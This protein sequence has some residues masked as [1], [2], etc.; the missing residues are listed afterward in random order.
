MTKQ[1]LINTYDSMSMPEEHVEAIEARLK[2][3]YDNPSPSS[4]P[5]VPEE[6]TREYKFDRKKPSAV[7]A[8]VIS[9]SAAAAA[10]LLVFGGRYLINGLPISSDPPLDAETEETSEPPYDTEEIR[11]ESADDI[12]GYERAGCYDEYEHSLIPGADSGKAGPLFTQRLR[13]GKPVSVVRIKITSANSWDEMNYTEYH[14][15]ITE[16]LS[17]KQL[18]LNISNEVTFR[19]GSTHSEQIIGEPSLAAGDELIA[20]AAEDGGEK[21]L[22]DPEELLFECFTVKGRNFA[23]QRHWY[24]LD[25]ADNAF[26]HQHGDIRRIT[27]VTDDPVSYYGIYEQGELAAALEKLVLVSDEALSLGTEP[28]PNLYSDFTLDFGL[29]EPFCYYWFD[30]NN[31]LISIDAREDIFGNVHGLDDEDVPDVYCAGFCEDE[32]GWYMQASNRNGGDSMY[33]IPKNDP[34]HMYRYDFGSDS[35]HTRSDYSERYIRQ[36]KG[37]WSFSDPNNDGS[38]YAS[39][40]QISGRQQVENY[41]GKISWLGKEK[42]CADHGE[43][44]AAE[45][46]KWYD[47]GETIEMDGFSYTR[48]LLMGAGGGKPPYYYGVGDV[49]LI[50]H[51]DTR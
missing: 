15:V 8:A 33:W 19:L 4:A 22:V 34:E 17:G 48:R 25:L 31:E 40:Q 47:C 37:G 43:S 9:I 46:N 32:L 28:L 36:G 29:V 7:K 41:V 18:N 49:W 16:C 21:S 42:L 3:L 14:A 12:P 44:W 30:E 5:E 50:D 24:W 20:A 10:V 13:D 27:T 26:N 39:A 51:T 35:S 6:S 1:E 45:F 11:F 38:F 23:A 2:K